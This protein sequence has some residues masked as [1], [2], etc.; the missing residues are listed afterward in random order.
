MAGMQGL[1]RLVPMVW[2]A[3]VASPAMAQQ[4]VPRA[5]ESSG[6]ISVVIALVLIVAVCVASFMSAKRTHQD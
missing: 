3:L 6:W 5:P 2:L 4:Q 1:L